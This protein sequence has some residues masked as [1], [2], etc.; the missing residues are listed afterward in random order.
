MQ[1][2]KVSALQTSRIGAGRSILYLSAEYVIGE[3]WLGAIVL[4]K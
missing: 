2:D 1:F 3:D 4:R